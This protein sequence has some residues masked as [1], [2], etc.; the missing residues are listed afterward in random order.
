MASW[1]QKTLADSGALSGIASTVD[2]ILTPITTLTEAVTTILDAA[3]I[4]L[5][6]PG[7]EI[8]ILIQT[9]AQPLLNDLN[10]Y[11]NLGFYYLLVNL[12]Y[13][14]CPFVYFSP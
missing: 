2:G 8:G 14:N 3:K 12:S 4:F 7:D 1:E 6:G 13:K 10:D 9:A 5:V 11:K